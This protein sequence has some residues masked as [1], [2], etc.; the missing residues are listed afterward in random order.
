M[1][2][3]ISI[4]I[5]AATPT[6]SN[7][8]IAS[9]SGP[10][11]PVASSTGERQKLTVGTEVFFRHNS[12]PT[13]RGKPAATAAPPL[14]PDGEG[15]LCSVTSVIGEGKQRRYEIRD[16]DDSA[17]TTPPWR[18]SVSALVAIPPIEMNDKLPV[19]GG[20][21]QV[22]ALY[23]GTTTFYKAEVASAKGDGKKGVV[24]LRFEGEDEM[25]KETEV[26]RRYVLPDPAVK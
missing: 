19:L 3:L 14:E 16:V 17:A 9:T 5:T 2:L 18:A 1:L 6:P 22:L 4:P 11:V 20:G 23:P 10:S 13:A 15:I 21:R 7:S 12:K 26:E 25:D 24:R 8:T